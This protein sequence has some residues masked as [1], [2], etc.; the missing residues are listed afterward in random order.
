MKRRGC[1]CCSGCLWLLL[2]ALLFRSWEES[3]WPLRGVEL[4]GLAAVVIA[5]IYQ[6]RR[7]SRSW[8][9]RGTVTGA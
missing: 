4:A 1:G 8:E 9:S 5:A 2:I 3:P 7:R 6:Q